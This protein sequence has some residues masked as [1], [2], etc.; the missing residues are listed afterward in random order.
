MSIAVGDQVRTPEGYLGRI[1]TLAHQAVPHG[2]W[3]RLERELDPQNRELKLYAVVALQEPA[4][5]RGHRSTWSVDVLEVVELNDGE[6]V[7]IAEERFS[8]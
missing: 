2:E 5:Y 8:G 3:W 4:R 1:V 6:R 7:E